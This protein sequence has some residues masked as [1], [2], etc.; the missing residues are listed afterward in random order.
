MVESACKLLALGMPKAALEGLGEDRTDPLSKLVA[1]Q[2]WIKLFQPNKALL[3]LE[4]DCPFTANSEIAQFNLMQGIALLQTNETANSL[5]KFQMAQ[6]K[7]ESEEFLNR[8]K[9]YQR[10][11]DLEMSN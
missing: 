1:A 3:E 11:A 6:E 8:V 9:L 10:K 5:V 7:G 2:C 4:G